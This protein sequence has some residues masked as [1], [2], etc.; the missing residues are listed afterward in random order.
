MVA[1]K[2]IELEG[3]IIDSLILPKAFDAIMDAGGDFDVLEFQIGKHKSDTSYARILIKADSREQLDY[4]LSELLKIGAKIPEVEEVRLR[5]APKDRTLPEG[6][7][8]TTN[9]PTYVLI[10]GEW[11]GVENIE[12]DVAIVVDT[13]NKSARGKPISDIKKGDLVVVGNRGIRVE[14]PERPRSYSMFE[15]MKSSVSSEKP[16]EILIKNIAETIKEV[17]EEGK[18]ILVVAGPAVV[19]TSAAKALASLI[20]AGYVDVFFAGNAVAVH[21]IESQLFGTSLGINLKTGK[22]EEGGHRHHLYAINEVMQAGS[23]ENLVRQ[24]KLRAGIMNELIKNN[25]PFVLAG[26]I[27]DDGPL[28][29]VITDVIEAQKAMRS[30]LEGV[31]L[32][33]MLSSMLHSIAVGN[34]LP[35]RVKTICVDINPATVTKLTDR[36]TAQALGVV[37]DVGT[38]L[39]ALKK[40][41]LG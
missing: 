9:H 31:G 19:H 41:I 23:I 17:K 6:F 21:D 2:E 20:K 27:R 18:K 34:I 10:S 39:P 16:V 12:M 7:Y 30:R 38:F 11:V 35:S 33:L 14:P 29:E 24:G 36:G 25:I 4:I 22:Q 40:E 28:P 32:V 13:E 26:S 3:H 1:V 37:T 5:L 15:F 8:S